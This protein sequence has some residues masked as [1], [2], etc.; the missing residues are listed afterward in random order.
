MALARSLVR[1]PQLLLAD[2]PF[3]ALDALTRIRMHGLLRELCAAHRP[4]VLLVTHD[5]DE[6]IALA[7]R[8]VVLRRRPGGY[9]PD[10]TLGGRPAA[11][12]QPTQPAMTPCAATSWPLSASQAP[13]T[14][15]ATTRT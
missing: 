3:G 2:E 6:A 1:E 5:V 4:A 15:R 10:R 8:I 11:G 7:D 14:E 13:A 12:T 9:G